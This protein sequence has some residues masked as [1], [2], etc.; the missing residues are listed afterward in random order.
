[1]WTSSSR[2]RCRSAAFWTSP[3]SRLGR[4]S[5]QRL[6]TLGLMTT[7]RYSWLLGQ[8]GQG[9]AVAHHRVGEYVTTPSPGLHGSSLD[10]SSPGGFLPAR[11]GLL[12]RRKEHFIRAATAVV[13]TSLAPGLTR[14]ACFSF[15]PLSFP[16]L[17]SLDSDPVGTQCLASDCQM[18]R[19]WSS[20]NESQ[21]FAVPGGPRAEERRSRSASSSGS[22][23][24]RTE[25][26]RKLLLL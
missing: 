3:V 20:G 6:G 8:R 26:T 19:A 5:S 16:L 25:R 12:S 21:N 13:P 15:S 18:S 7:A 1:M 22:T 23:H 14:R 9:G 11:S 17:A 24:E 10:P 2:G 4:G